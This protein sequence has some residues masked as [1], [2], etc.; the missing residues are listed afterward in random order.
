MGKFEWYDPLNFTTKEKPLQDYLLLDSATIHNLDLL[1][2]K[3]SLKNTL[4]RCETA[5]GKRYVN[6]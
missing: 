1:E 3:I 4:D 5:F 2:T 6:N